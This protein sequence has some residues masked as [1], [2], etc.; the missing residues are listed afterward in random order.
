MAN[1]GDRHVLGDPV[2]RLAR[3]AS[4]T[5]LHEQPVRRLSDADLRRQLVNADTL[6]EEAPWRGTPSWLVDT[7]Q[8]R[9]GELFAEYRG[10]R[11]FP[12]R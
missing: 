3:G 7:L 2:T 6:I 8:R 9:R 11:L 12:L 4:A 5:L 10:R 1:D